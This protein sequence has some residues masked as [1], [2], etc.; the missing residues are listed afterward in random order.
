MWFLHYRYLV[1]GRRGSNV[2]LIGFKPNSVVVHCDSQSSNAIQEL[3]M[4]GELDQIHLF[5][6]LELMRKLCLTTREAIVGA[7]ADGADIM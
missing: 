3:I 7:T 1:G 6:K 2:P 4:G 5:G